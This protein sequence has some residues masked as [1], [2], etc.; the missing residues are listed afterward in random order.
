MGSNKPRP[1]EEHYIPEP[2]SGCFL[3]LNA[4]GAAGYGWI[5]RGGQHYQAHRYSWIIHR[6]P[7]PPGM[8]VLHK[9][10]T[11]SCVN[12]DHLRLGTQ[13]DNN[14]DRMRKGRSRNQRGTEHH[15][16]KLT[17][18]EVLAIRSDTRSHRL[19]ANDYGVSLTTVAKIRRQERW[20]HVT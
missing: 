9:C 19:T 5:M 7:I 10:D 17:E 6:G 13:R 8:S 20:K 4:L 11:P 1:F 18:A 15:M 16:A 2:N 3:W 12:P 14:L